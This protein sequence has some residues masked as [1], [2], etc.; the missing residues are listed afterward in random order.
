[1]K[2]NV[3]KSK[4]FTFFYL[5]KS[6]REGNKVKTRNIRL[7]G[8][9]DAQGE[10]LEALY[11]Y[12]K[13]EVLK[14]NEQFKKS[15]L[16]FQE[17]IDFSETFKDQDTS[18][19]LSTI[20]NIGFLYLEKVIND[21]DLKK[22][23]N[24]KCDSYKF[25]FSLLNV[26]KL[27]TFSRILAPKSKLSTFDECSTYLKNFDLSLM[28]IYRGLDVISEL[29]NSLQTHLYKMSE[30][31]LPRK[32]TVLYYDC[33]NYYFETEDEHDGLRKYGVSKEHRPSPIVQMGLFIDEEGI[34]LAFDIHP[35][36]TN[37]QKTAI[38]LEKKIIRDFSLSKF[39][40]CSDA[41]L[42]SE[43][44]KRFN[45][46]NNRA[47]IV[48]QSL[49]K[50]NSKERELIFKDFNWRFLYDD[51]LASVEEMK[52]ICDKTLNH[53]KLS[54]YEIN[55][56]N[57]DIIYKDFPYKDERIIVT[58][59]AKSYIYQRN[60]FANQ[61]ERANRQI[62]KNK[63]IKYG[64]ND[65]RRLLE[66]I[67]TDDEGVIVENSSLIL[68]NKQIDKECLY[69]GF[70]ALATNL[71]DEAKIIFKLN[72]SRWKVEDCFRIMKTSFKARPVY[73]QKENRIRAHFLTCYLA[74][75][76]FSLL[77]TKIEDKSITDEDIIKTLRNMN[78]MIHEKGF[79]KSLYSGSKTLTELEKAFN[80]QL[81]HKY[82]EENRLIKMKK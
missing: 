12:Y 70:Y 40:Y 61:L 41:G 63:K 3:A 79:G 30:K 18:H 67:K 45:S 65:P 75:L 13:N 16:S 39:I 10:E 4:N 15:L 71:E 77:K 80:L 9:T 55:I 57:K 28:D 52:Q 81:N 2:L 29:S 76:V 43:D 26:L 47:Y 66:E 31:I 51:Q 48:S 60:I 44:I 23:I 72:K 25:K 24:D 54:E 73:L 5:A 64:P 62:E 53:E 38:P 21:L 17:N 35:G 8:K 50:I 68:N 33:T 36:N 78:I 6:I 82:Y 58:F 49:K 59:S 74:L 27:L 46:F 22:F 34:P 1:M 69:H 37:E 32:K 7:L 11:L 42:C 19:S 20:K 56:L 14:A